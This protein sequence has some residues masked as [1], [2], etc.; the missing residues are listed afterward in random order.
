M[1]G[2]IWLLGA[3][4]MTRVGVTYPRFTGWKSTKKLEPRPWPARLHDQCN[5]AMHRT[6]PSLT[7]HT[8]CPLPNPLPLGYR[9]PDSQGVCLSV[10]LETA[11]CSPSQVSASNQSESLGRE[12]QPIRAVSRFNNT[13]HRQ[14]EHV[15]IFSPWWLGVRKSAERGTPVLW[16]LR[17]KFSPWH[18]IW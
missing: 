6:P 11:G 17:E 16:L 5:S 7:V 3:Q 18:M 2:W 10:W 1:D 4:T 15:S 13:K 12:N 14:P 8:L 9:S